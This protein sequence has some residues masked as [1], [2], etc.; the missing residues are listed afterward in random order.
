MEI[1]G[2]L[3]DRIRKTKGICLYL[4]LLSLLAC[5][6]F[7]GC[8]G[9]GPETLK[10]KLIDFTFNNIILPLQD[11]PNMLIVLYRYPLDGSDL[12]EENLFERMWKYEHGKL[13]EIALDEFNLLRTARDDDKRWVYSQHSI[14][15]LQLEEEKYE[16]VVEVGSLYGPLAGEGTRY[17]LKYENGEWKI[18]NEEM[19]WK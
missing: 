2:R 11:Q 1:S 6:L 12:S 9:K 16:A 10:D 8:R 17:W 15:I 18:L 3:A 7:A 19:V 14:T 5:L 4:A 13:A